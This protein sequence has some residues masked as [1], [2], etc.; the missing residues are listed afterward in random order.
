[1]LDRG[2][3]A[4]AWAATQPLKDAGVGLFQNKAGTGLRK[5]HHKLM[6][7]DERLVIL[8]SFN[9][10]APATTLNDEN[11]IVLGDLEEQDPQAEA[12]QRQLAGF[13]LRE[14]DRIVHELAEPV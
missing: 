1:M 14:I 6:V 7:I 10:T 9:F 11:I 12:A 8:G 4:Q 3:G 5:V 13:S 2:Q